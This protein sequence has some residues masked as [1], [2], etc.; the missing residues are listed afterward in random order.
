[1]FNLFRRKRV[2]ALELE[3]LIS[4]FNGLGEEYSTYA[5]QVMGGLLNRVYFQSD[6]IKNYIGFFYNRD[7][8]NDYED[9]KGP[10]F[11]LLGIKFLR[12]H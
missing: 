10:A 8:V 3:L 9:R 1:M 4:I 6:P 7:V 12:I 2:S 5:R 11:K